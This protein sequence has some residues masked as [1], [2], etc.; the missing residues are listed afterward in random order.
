MWRKI[1]IDQYLNAFLGEDP[2]VLKVA[3]F[4]WSKFKIYA[5]KSNNIYI[6]A[7]PVRV[8]DY[9]SNFSSIRVNYMHVNFVCVTGCTT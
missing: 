5:R 3:F 6:F 2:C 8:N 9:L 1:C 7:I 4:D